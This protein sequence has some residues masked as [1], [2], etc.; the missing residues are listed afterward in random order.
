M[1]RTGNVIVVNPRLP[2]ILISNSVQVEFEGFALDFG[3]LSYL[4]ISLGECQTA[5]IFGGIYST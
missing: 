3:V 2:Y 4:A 1:L 5:G